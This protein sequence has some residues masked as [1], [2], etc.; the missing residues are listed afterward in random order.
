MKDRDILLIILAM[1]RRMDNSDLNSDLYWSAWGHCS[2]SCGEGVETRH[3]ECV[4]VYNVDGIGSIERV[5]DEECGGDAEID[6]RSCHVD[7]CRMYI[8]QKT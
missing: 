1:W 2:A 8:S 6:S 7:F 4:R 3:R 5:D